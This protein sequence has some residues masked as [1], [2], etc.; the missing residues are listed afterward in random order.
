MSDDVLIV[1]AGPAGIGMAI[2]LKAR[3]VT[4]VRI[5]DKT[6]I[7]ASFN[8]WPEDTRFITPSFPS[9]AYGCPDLNSIEPDR[10][11]GGELGNDRLSGKEYATYLKHAVTR[12]DLRIE[13]PV[14]VINLQPHAEG[15]WEA[16]TS[17]GVIHSL[18]L[19]VVGD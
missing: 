2:T 14:E 9:Q 7:G 17:E 11:P 13:A 15:G 10:S 4:Q 8:A 5:L 18:P 16:Q 12:N 3:G 1:G 6:G 19:R